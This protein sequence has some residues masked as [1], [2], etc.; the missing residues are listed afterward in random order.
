[1][2]YVF[3]QRNIEFLSYL[4]HD[5]GV[6]DVKEVLLQ[7]GDVLCGG[8]AA[9]RR[10]ELTQRLWPLYLLLRLLHVLLLRGSLQWEREEEVFTTR[11]KWVEGVLG[12]GS[13]LVVIPPSC[14][15]M[16]TLH[17]NCIDI[18]EVGY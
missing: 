12:A 4:T 11:R 17:H 6:G 14:Q 3:F 10:D 1:M 13:I 16:N 8:R 18:N 2:I 9:E 15:Y 7:G 5:I